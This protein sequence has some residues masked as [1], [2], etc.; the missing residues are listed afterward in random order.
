MPLAARYRMTSLLPEVI[1]DGKRASYK[2]RPR[3]RGNLQRL[4]EI[5]AVSAA[6]RPA[7]LS[8]EAMVESYERCTNNFSAGTTRD[9]ET[10][11]RQTIPRQPH[12]HE[13]RNPLPVETFTTRRGKHGDNT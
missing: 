11:H 2:Q 7:M 4:S 1:K 6:N 12:P 10:G 13:G 8:I 3:S 9:H 5:I